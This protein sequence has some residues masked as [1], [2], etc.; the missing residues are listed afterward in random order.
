M[1]NVAVES[2][3]RAQEMI[4]ILI[5]IWERVLKHSAIRSDEN[6]FDLGGDSL[7]AVA[8]FLEIEKQTGRKLPITII[9]DAP[10]IASL[11]A[12]LEKS[13]TL[14]K[15][16]PLVLLKP[17]DDAPPLFMMH[18]LGATVLGLLDLAK[19]TP[20][21]H[22]IYGV[23]PRG[24]DGVEAPDQRLEDM[25]RYCLAA[26]DEVQPHGPYLL[27]G[28]S[29]GG[30][31]MLEVAHRILERGDDV[32]LLAMV[33]SYPHP[34]FWPLKTWLGV[35]W[36]R[37]RYH[38]SALGRLE[39]RQVIPYVTRRSANLSQHI[40]KR[41]G[42][43]F[44]R[45]PGVGKSMPEALNEVLRCSI[46]ALASYRPRYYPGKVTFLQ[47]SL[48]AQHPDDARLVWGKLAGRHPDDVR[49]IWG[50]LVQELELHEAAQDHAAPTA[51]QVNEA[52]EWLS[53]CI[54][55]ATLG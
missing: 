13:D 43:H 7:L 17:G 49:L 29:F 21:R 28:L 47:A 36:R 19:R 6:F 50:K 2:Y 40:R 11:A 26:I 30:V 55:R 51:S 1:S 4:D 46:L 48:A 20:S 31:V 38:A 15:I 12:V 18:G 53:R 52:A 32:A 44:E 10:T 24:S 34:R 16:S 41:G 25:A 45:E 39:L 23:Q 27:A 5:P 8:L 14:P 9:Y 54:D 33:D 22:P 35:L 3:E 37:A 42:E